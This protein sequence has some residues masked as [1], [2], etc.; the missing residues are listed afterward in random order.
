MKKLFIVLLISGITYNAFGFECN[1][2]RNSDGAILASKASETD[3]GLFFNLKANQNSFFI[4]A[5][6]KFG[7]QPTIYV[8]DQEGPIAEASR[9]SPKDGDN[10][11]SLKLYRYDMTVT[12][13]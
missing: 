3:T 10:S 8:K 13:Q 9:R 2:T 7:Q 12:C 5:H 1:I 4:S 11:I 6:T